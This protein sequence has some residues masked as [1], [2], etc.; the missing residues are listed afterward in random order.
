VAEESGIWAIPFSIGRLETEGERFFIAETNSVPSISLDGTLVYGSE[1]DAIERQMIWVSRKGRVEGIIGQA[2][3]GITE[4]ALSPDGLDIAVSAMDPYNRDIWIHEAKRPIKRPVTT[5]VAN[6]GQPVWSPDGQLLAF[7]S[8]GDLFVKPADGSGEALPLVTSPPG[9]GSPVW[10]RDGRYIVGTEWTADATSDLWY[11][12]VAS[13]TSTAP[14]VGQP[15]ALTQTLEINEGVPHLSY[16]GRHIAY[17]SDETGQYEVYIRTFPAWTDRVQVSTDGGVHPRWSSHGN[18]MFYVEGNRLMVVKIEIQP[19]L[20]V[21]VSQP[22]FTAESGWIFDPGLAEGPYV[23]MYD[24]TPDGQR[25]VMIRTLESD[26]T[27][28]ITVVQ[29]WYAGFKDKQ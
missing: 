7:S 17:Q 27:P 8:E 21:A 19:R 20:S 11:V 2:Q 9:A 4:P 14:D 15:I 3:I 18:E 6:E 5:D 23:R 13:S 1:E 24:V 10:S 16:D 25:F 29:N 22:V 26:Y 28:T 12:P